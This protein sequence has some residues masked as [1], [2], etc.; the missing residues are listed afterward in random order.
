MADSK[1]DGDDA[2]PSVDSNRRSYSP[3][4]DDGGVGGASSSSSSSS[5]SISATAPGKYNASYFASDSKSDDRKSDSDTNIEFRGYKHDSSST[6]SS[7][8]SSSS[9]RSWEQLPLE[10][11][12]DR[13]SSSISTA[14]TRL[15]EAQIIDVEFSSQSYALEASATKLLD[16]SS[17]DGALLGEID[18]AIKNLQFW[19]SLKS[20]SKSDETAAGGEVMSTAVFTALPTMVLYSSGS[21]AKSKSKSNERRI[22]TQQQQ[23]EDDDNNKEEEE[24]NRST[25]TGS[26]DHLQNQGYREAVD[27][28]ITI[29]YVN[30]DNKEEQEEEEDDDEEKYNANSNEYNDILGLL[31]F[32]KS[33]LSGDIKLSNTKLALALDAATSLEST[34]RSPRYERAIVGS[35]PSQNSQKVEAVEAK[36]AGVKHIEDEVRDLTYV[37]RLQLKDKVRYCV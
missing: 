3:R 26:L 32:E 29:K 37:Q 25:M 2:H 20:N 28:G 34:M 24:V 15:L 36:I 18:E 5:I 19:R 13:D 1:Y 23:Q 11:G 10:V 21:K 6:S 27:D 31:K 30:D 9:S 4:C 35:A 33:K 22:K 12:R 7:S 17:D 14:R 16:N 8:S